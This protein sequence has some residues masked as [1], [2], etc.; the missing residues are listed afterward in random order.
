MQ[1]AVFV[2]HRINSTAHQVEADSSRLR[3]GQAFGCARRQPASRAGFTGQKPC[4][5]GA[6]RVEG[7]TRAMG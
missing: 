3:L 1:L 2:L 6:K 7:L 4:P 5:E